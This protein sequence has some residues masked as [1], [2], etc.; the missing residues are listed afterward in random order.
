MLLIFLSLFLFYSLAATSLTV[1]NAVNSVDAVDIDVD[2]ASIADNS[3]APDAWPPLLPSVP[4]ISTH[5]NHVTYMFTNEDAGQTR[6]MQQ[7]SKYLLDHYSHDI[8][9]HHIL[10]LS[11]LDGYED[12][13][14]DR[15]G[16][17]KGTTS[18]DMVVI[19]PG[20]Y[21]IHVNLFKSNTLAVEVTESEPVGLEASLAIYRTLKISGQSKD[22]DLLVHKARLE[23][24]HDA[25]DTIRVYQSTVWGGWD[26]GTLSG[27]S[28][29]QKRSLKTVFLDQGMTDRILN[30]IKRFKERSAVYKKHGIPYHRNYLLTGPPGTGKTSLIHALAS[31][32]NMGLSVINF[33]RY[34]TKTALDRNMASLPKN[35]II[36]VED[37]DALYT[38][39]RVGDPDRNGLTFSDFINA[40][41]GFASSNDGAIVF[42]TTN[43]PD[44]MDPALLRPGRVDLRL[45]LSYATQGQVQS[46][47]NAYYES[48]FDEFYRQFFVLGLENRLTTASLQNFF[49]KHLDEPDILSK[50]ADLLEYLPPAVVTEA[51]IRSE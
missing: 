1:V 21:E 34:Y 5:G 50:I 19:A 26:S 48:G 33:H 43:H 15:W 31:D 4:E 46:V 22:I 30:D 16:N 49:F 10:S 45:S 7:V 47:Y 38:I 44:R 25:E 51:G 27:Y 29:L 8:S 35:T 2:S 24:Q 6:L 28:T 20:C 36:V 39:D 13:R 40:I 11:D 42:M 9:N 32:L 3:W 41:D 23:S 17:S 18:G 14:T 37:I 12:T